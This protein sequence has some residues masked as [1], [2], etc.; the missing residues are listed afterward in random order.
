[1]IV[2]KAQEKN[3]KQQGSLVALHQSTYDW[4]KEGSNSAEYITEVY[5]GRPKKLLPLLPIRA[6]NYVEDELR[7]KN[8]AAHVKDF[9]THLSVNNVRM[10]RQHPSIIK[11]TF[12]F[13]DCRLAF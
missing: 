2:G 5:P 12:N 4:P 10:R 11:V 1:M 8:S 3:A 13:Q 6:I 7:F 9:P